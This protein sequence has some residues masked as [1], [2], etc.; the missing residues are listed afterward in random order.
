[1]KF[2]A[3]SS[4]I[5]ILVLFVSF[6]N[7]QTTP[8]NSGNKAIPAAELS[9]ETDDKELAK[10][11][12]LNEKQYGEFKKINQEYKAKAKEAKKGRKEE[13][14]KMRD[15]RMA[16]HKAMLTPDQARKYDEIM[17]KRETEKA[18]KKAEKKA[19]KKAAKSAKKKET[20]GQE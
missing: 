12:N 13:M 18:A 20:K 15:E 10:A 1:M 11:L 19:E 3:K 5:A 16:A 7:A 8:G 2:T 6:L 14:K 4:L 17:A 9:T